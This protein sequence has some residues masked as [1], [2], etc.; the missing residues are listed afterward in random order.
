MFTACMVL[1]CHVQRSDPNAV[2]RDR[3]RPFD[4]CVEFDGSLSSI[5]MLRIVDGID[6]WTRATGAAFTWM[7][8]TDERR[9]CRRTIT[10]KRSLST[11]DWVVEYDAQHGNKVLGMCWSKKSGRAVV[12]L[13]TDRL[14]DG[15]GM[16]IVA[17]HEFAHAMGAGH[18]DDDGSI[19]RKRVG[20]QR[21]CVSERDIAEFCR[22]MNCVPPPDP[23]C[24][25]GS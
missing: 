1:S 21:R 7:L 3:V 18:V 17:A 15:V 4:A 11:D 20:P 13:V 5:E 6:M 24:V 22:G 23:V 10:F 19:M 16:T 2:V 8:V 9:P 12:A 14:V 25:P